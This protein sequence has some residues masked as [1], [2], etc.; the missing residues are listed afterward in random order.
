M[1]TVE[2]IQIE[3]KNVEKAVK[4]DVIGLKVDARC[5]KGDKV[6]QSVI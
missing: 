4:G 3:H 2:S 6:K 5:R 1:Q